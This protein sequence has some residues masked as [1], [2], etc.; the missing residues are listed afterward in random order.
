MMDSLDP[1]RKMKSQT[2]S[3]NLIYHICQQ[4]LHFISLHRPRSSA[5]A[6]AHSSNELF[7]SH[8]MDPSCWVPCLLFRDLS[9]EVSEAEVSAAL[10]CEVDAALHELWLAG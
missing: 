4:T 2:R 6:D 10:E 7:Q 8:F 1:K 5:F 9:Q 3:A